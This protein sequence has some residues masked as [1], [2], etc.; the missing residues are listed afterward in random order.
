M[1]NVKDRTKSGSLGVGGYIL[2][3]SLSALSPLTAV[4]IL[5]GLPGMV[6]DLD[7]TLSAAQLA[8][9]VGFAGLA[10]GL[11][12]VGPLSD[13]FGRR[14][15]VVIGLVC[16]IGTTLMCAVAPDISLLI[17]FRLAQG[18]AGGAVWVITRAVIRDVYAGRASARAFSQMAMI[19]GLAPVVA[20]FIAGQLLLFVD[21]RGLFIVLAAVGGVVLVLALLFMFETLAPE[22]R[23]SEGVRGQV[24]ATLSVLRARHFLS[25]LSLA[26]IQSIMY[27]T[28]VIMSP[29]VFTGDFG[30][31]EQGFG[32]F[33]GGAALAMALGNQTNVLLL[34]RWN[35]EGALLFLLT[36][37]LAGSAAFLVA[38]MLHAPLPVVIGAILLVSFAAGASN[39]NIT[40]LTLAPYAHAAGTAA[41]VLGASQFGVAALVPPLVSLLG[42]D[43]VTMGITLVVTALGAWAIG[44]LL[45]PRRSISV[46]AA[47]SESDTHS[48]A[49]VD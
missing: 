43:G 37:A 21:W 28:F 5:P 42:V 25:Y 2:L 39:A 47:A 4:F 49:R 9:S 10:V 29:F 19:T 30:M 13:R 7:T 46:P 17:A 24:R 26:I 34:R 15:P 38:S 41:A 31:S 27:F 18:I 32:L 8:L 6:G 33:Y 16:Y 11:L 23:Q 12:V 3:A 36:L 20:P 48:V 44:I 35:P 45:R 1:K 14:W 22:R 40:A